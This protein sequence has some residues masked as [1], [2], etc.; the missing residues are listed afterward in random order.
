M[1]VVNI[2]FLTQPAPTRLAIF[3]HDF[4][5]SNELTLRIPYFF[6]RYAAP[7]AKLQVSSCLFIQNELT[8]FR[9][10]FHC[11]IFETTHVIVV[12]LCEAV[13][14]PP[15]RTGGTL[16]SLCTFC[17]FYELAAIGVDTDVNGRVRQNVRQP[18]DVCCELCPVRNGNVTNID[19]AT[20]LIT[21]RTMVCTGTPHDC[22]LM[23]YVLS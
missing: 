11:F 12:R 19:F 14:T 6:R 23:S 4:V 9:T 10:V 3:T 22:S 21:E 18:E 2:D 15:R 13:T 7:R 20:T 5:T 16:S 17:R 1:G 8:S